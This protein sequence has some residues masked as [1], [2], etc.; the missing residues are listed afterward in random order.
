M[1]FG[2]GELLAFLSR[3]FRLQPGDLVATGTPDGVG[4]AR[5]PPWLLRPG[6]VV[7]VDIERVGRVTTPVVAG[8]AIDDASAGETVAVGGK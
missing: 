3:T 4:Y 2:V 8:P 6:D 7:D 1:L 5:T